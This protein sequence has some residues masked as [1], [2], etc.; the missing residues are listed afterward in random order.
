MKAY[1]QPCQT[2]KIKV[3]AEIVKKLNLIFIFAKK[4]HFRCFTEI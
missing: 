3:F 4:L 2:S 1:S